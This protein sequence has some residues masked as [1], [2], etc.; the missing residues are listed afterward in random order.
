MATANL[1]PQITL[2]GNVGSQTLQAGK[3]FSSGSMA[4]SIAAGLTQPLFNGGALQ[5]R[6]R[7]AIAAY[8]QAGAQYEQT[9]L[10]AFLNVANTLRAL[11]SDADALH[12]QAD[13]ESLARQSLDIVNRQYKLGATNYLAL[14]DAQRTYLQTKV[15]L[16]QAQANRLADSAALFQALGGGWWNRPPLDDISVG[17]SAGTVV[18][19]P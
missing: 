5:A 4:W 11:A 12:A 6:R 10:N 3:L 8:D 18:A 7:A 14:L 15:G 17:A 9:V 1:Y 13:A 2:S 16:A 19:K